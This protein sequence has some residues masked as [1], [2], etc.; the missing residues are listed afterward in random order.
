MNHFQVCKSSLKAIDAQDTLPSKA[1]S[2][3]KTASLAV[4]LEN[5]LLSQASSF[6]GQSLVATAKGSVS[7]L[8]Q[9]LDTFLDSARYS[10]PILNIELFI[11]YLTHYRFG[12]S[13]GN[14]DLVIGACSHYMRSIQSIS[15]DPMER[16]LL[17]EPLSEL[18]N[19]AVG[20]IPQKTK[21][22]VR[23]YKHA[24]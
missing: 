17:I 1:L 5:E 15:Q 13:A 16:G 23:T 6:R 19:L 9:A 24:L 14:Y 4:K 11:I 7:A 12:H 3:S 8:R 22:E 10:G 18:L 2:S 21:Q 20:L